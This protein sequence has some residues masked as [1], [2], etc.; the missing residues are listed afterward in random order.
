PEVSQRPIVEYVAGLMRPPISIARAAWDVGRRVVGQFIAAMTA[1]PARVHGA[2]P[3]PPP[4][5][6]HFVQPPLGFTLPSASLRCGNS[7]PAGA[8]FVPNANA[9]PQPRHTAS[10]LVA[11]G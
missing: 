6:V 8:F 2:P 3:S 9:A 11:H 7:T 5:G 4:L 1:D 10:W